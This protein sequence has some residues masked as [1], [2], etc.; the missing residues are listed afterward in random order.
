MFQVQ[1]LTGRK[2]NY[3][4]QGRGETTLGRRLLYMLHELTPT[5]IA[6]FYTTRPVSLQRNMSNAPTASRTSPRPRSGTA[7][8]TGPR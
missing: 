2:A 3:W 8:R 5:D 6:F 4:H 7:S 1:W